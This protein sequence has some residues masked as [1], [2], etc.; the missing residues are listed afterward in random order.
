MLVMIDEFFYQ[1]AQDVVDNL[2]FY[3]DEFFTL[4]NKGS[5]QVFVFP[6]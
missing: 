2:I 1:F 3:I 4:L 5:T 6:Y